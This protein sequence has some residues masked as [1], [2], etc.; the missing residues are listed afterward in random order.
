M[1]QKDYEP[2]PAE[3]IRYWVVSRRF[4]RTRIPIWSVS[5][6]AD[7]KD[8]DHSYSSGPIIVDRMKTPP[9]QRHGSFGSSTDFIV[10]DGKHRIHD[11]IEEQKTHINAF[12]GDAA[13]DD[14]KEYIREFSPVRQRFAQALEAYYGR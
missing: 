5:T 12:V 3:E 1:K 14:L 7:I 10:I 13:Y 4:K 11:H 8:S 2:D 6:Y 9:K